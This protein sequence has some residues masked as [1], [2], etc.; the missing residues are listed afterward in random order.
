[1][2]RLGNT[3]RT[4]FMDSRAYRVMHKIVT[5]SESIEVFTI[6]L[7]FPSIVGDRRGMY[8]MVEPLCIKKRKFLRKK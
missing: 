4:A 2:K 8:R 5:R 7:V 6:E 3:M 1:M